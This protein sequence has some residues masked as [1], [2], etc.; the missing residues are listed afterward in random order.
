MSVGTSLVTNEEG[1]SVFSINE[2]CCLSFLDF[3]FSRCTFV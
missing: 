1:V 3:G 2:M